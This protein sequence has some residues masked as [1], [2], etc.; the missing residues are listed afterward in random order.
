MAETYTERDLEKAYARGVADTEALLLPFD[1]IA[2][3]YFE[4]DRPQL[5]AAISYEQRLV[6]KLDSTD[7]FLDGALL[8]RD[9][10]DEDELATARRGREHV[11]AA[12]GSNRVSRALRRT[13]ARIGADGDLRH[14]RERSAENNDRVHQLEDLQARLHQEISAVRHWLSEQAGH[15]EC[16]RSA[17]PGVP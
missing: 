8:M 16:T 14:V 3:V 1:H 15:L 10:S 5:E 11:A 7:R 13:V 2:D 17:R 4:R 6:A 9:H 12:G